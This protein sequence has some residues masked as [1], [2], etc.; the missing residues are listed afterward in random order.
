[1]VGLGKRKKKNTVFLKAAVILNETV[2]SFR[3][4]V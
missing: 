2:S 4:R 1:M 3:F